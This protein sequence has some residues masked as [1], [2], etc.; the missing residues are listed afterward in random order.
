MYHLILISIVVC[1]SHLFALENG[2]DIQRELQKNNLIIKQKKKKEKSIL[3][4]LGNLRKNIYMTQRKLNNA[5]YRYNSY[6]QQIKDTET[7]LKNEEANLIKTKQY[8]TQKIARLYKEQNRPVIQLLFNSES[9]SSLLNNMYFYE[10][11]IENEYFELVNAR[12]RINTHKINKKK[13]ELSR[14]K[15]N[16]LKQTIMKQRYEL[17]DTKRRFQKNL[18]SL[19]GELEKYERRNKLLREESQQLSKFIQNRTGNGN[20]VY[21]GTGAYLRPVGGYISSRFG[22]RRHPIFKRRRMH[23]GMDFA[24]PRGYRIKAADSGKVLFSGF[25][26]GYGNVTIIDHGWKQNK[27]ISSLYAHQWKILVRKGQMVDKGQLIGYVGS[28]GYSTGPHLHFE[29]RENGTPVNPSQYLR[30]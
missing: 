15:A 1:F 13:L 8:L 30:L 24:A 29:I 12:E 23:N 28:T 7:K 5:F 14:T 3:K 26:K 21:Y 10:K 17:K 9:F 2:A 6:H 20:K 4:E 22:L 18:T 27:K 19:R 16:E 11:I 25:K